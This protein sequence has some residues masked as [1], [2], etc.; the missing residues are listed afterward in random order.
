MARRKTTRLAF[1]ALMVEGA[2]IAPDMIADVA[3]LKATAQSEADYRIPPGLKLRDEIGRSWRI[4]EA[5]WARFS[6]A[7]AGGPASAATQAFVDDLLR[8][9]FGFASLEVVAA[10]QVGSRA[11]PVQRVALSGRVPIAVAPAGDGLDRGLDQFS[12]EHRKRSASLLVQELLNADDAASWGIATDGL[13]LRLL[14]DNASLTRPAYVEADLERIFRGGLYADF[15]ALWLLIHESRFGGSDALPSDCP[16][17]RWREAGREA[18]AKARDRLGVGVEAALIEFGAG[19]VEHPANGV[20]RDAIEGGTL[21][22]Q[23]FYEELLR[24]VYRMIFLFTTEDRGLLHDPKANEAAKALYADGYSLARLRTQAARRAARDANHDLYEGLKIVFRSLWRG[25]EA[26]GLPALGG[27]FRD[28]ALPNLGNATISNKR[29]LDA[30]F[31]LAWI[32]EDHTLTRVNWRDMETEELGSVYESLLELTPRVDLV[33]RGFF[34]AEGAETKGNARK[35]SGSYYTPDSLVQLLLD[36]A[37]DPVI[38][39]TVN[40]NP[41]R[42]VEALL[43]LTVIDPACGS[44]HFLLAA[45]RRLATRVAQL[46]SPGAP[47]AEDWRHALREVARRCLFGV[48]R[49]PMAVELCQTALWI[50]SVEPGKPLT[51][52]DNHIRC[53]DSLIGVFDYETLRQGIPDEAFKALTGDDKDTARAYAKYN[54]QQRDGK[55]ATGFLGSLKPPAGLI[56]AARALADMPEDSLDDIAAKQAAFKRLHSGDNWLNLKTA[57]DCYV[58]AFFAPKTGGAPPPAELGRPALPLTDHVWAATRGSTLYGPLVALADGIANSARA[59]HWPIEFPHVFARGGFDVVVGNPPW[60]RIKLQEQEFFAARCP[61]I[62]TAQ[63]KAAREK[64]ISALGKAEANS[65]EARLLAEFHFAKRTAEASSEFVRGSGRYPLTGTGDVN[66][67]ALFAELFARLA[68]PRGRSGVLVPTGIATDSSTSAFFGNLIDGSKLTNLYSFYEIRRWFKDTDDRKPFCVLGIGSTTGPAEFCFNIDNI[69]ELAKAERRFT[70][71]A[72]EIAYINPNTKTAPVFRCRAD[73]DLTSKLYDRA[74]VLIKERTHDEGGDVNPWGVTFQTLFHMSNDSGLFRTPQQLMAD[75]WIREDT[76]WLR[77]TQEG[78]E[79][80]VPLY[81][82]KMIHHFDHRWATYAGDSLDEEG[83][84]DATLAERQ[85]PNFE[86]SPRYWVPEGEVKLRAARVPSSLKRGVREANPERVQKTLAEW[87]TGAFAALEGRAMCEADLT[88]ILG[89]DHSWRS[90]L[91]ASPDRFLREAKTLANGAEM[92]RETPLDR[93]DMAFL[94]ECPDAPLSLAA[95]LIN[96][97]QPR[98]LMGWRDICRSTDERTVIAS[99]FPKVGA[100]DKILIIHPRQ[101]IDEGV[102]IIAVLSSLVFDYICRQKFG[103][104]SLKYYYIKQLPVPPPSAFTR[105]DLAFVMPRVLELTYTSHSMRPWAEDLGHAGPPFAWNE[106]RRALLRAELDAFVARK[107]KLTRDELRYVLDPTDAKGA[108]YPSETFRVLKSKEVSRFGEYR[109]RRLVLSAWDQFEAGTLTEPSVT[110]ATR[111]SPSIAKPPLELSTVPAGAWARHDQNS[112]AAAQ[113]IL[114]AALKAL[115]SAAPSRQVRETAVLSLEP[116]ALMHRLTPDERVQWRRVVGAEAE[117]LHGATRLVQADNAAWRDATVHL[118]AT[119]RLLENLTDD[120]WAA[121][122]GLDQ[123][124]TAGWAD[125][126]AQFVLSI[127]QRTTADSVVEDA[128]IE[129]QISALAG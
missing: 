26:L 43:E 119:G 59:L 46:R 112:A 50:E 88:R 36:S 99:V 92:Q 122:H 44:G 108:D 93:D 5:L 75:G 7:R 60:E 71:S 23:V 117:P 41:G 91:G 68:R 66:T 49:N 76:D 104:T 73:A 18:G 72:E 1:D 31:R 84:R 89:R 19:F 127:L 20:L 13:K 28:T 61:E 29:L 25:E 10:R 53:G 54:K 116:R 58:A 120:T 105:A 47:S 38:E 110:F 126:R 94:V 78:R 125:G 6:Q 35:T 113:A 96:R 121:G 34:F 100:G 37:L 83:A 129:E 118:R 114:A 85:N 16:L 97:R 17:E 48:D 8:Q 98:W 102:F 33:V 109:T 24:L 39:R 27:L 64:L 52:L 95:T 115:P 3:A 42:A 79:R 65:A 30:V 2:L 69:S 124:P 56:D 57:C 21:T 63:N 128:E 15:V 9:V 103:G 14:R 62:A 101:R 106:D 107:Y 74:A 40:E 81:E 86:P 45:G 77:E 51:F 55:G 123:F 22:P 11:F 82:A 70:L 67:Y 80:R 90:V 4:A 111:A 87:L 32:I 12:E